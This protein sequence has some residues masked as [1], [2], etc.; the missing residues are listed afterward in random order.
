VTNGEFIYEF[1][2][3]NGNLSYLTATVTR[4][5]KVLPAITLDGTST[6]DIEYGN[7]YTE[8]GATRTDNVDGSGVVMN[9]VESIDT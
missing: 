6:I 8:L 5:D 7:E 3:M 1:E 9:I 4:I 2:D